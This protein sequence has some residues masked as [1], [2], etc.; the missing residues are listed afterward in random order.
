MLRLLSLAIGCL[1]VGTA[2]C[3]DASEALG[4]RPEYTAQALTQVAN[5][6]AIDKKIWAPGLDEG[7]VPQGI[8]YIDRALYMSAYLSRSKRQSRG[9]CRLYR[10]SPDRGTVTGQLDLPGNCGHAGGL[11]RGP[12][13]TLFV[14]DTR[15]LYLVTLDAQAAG[16]I[17]RVTKTVRLTGDVRGSFAAGRGRFLWLGTYRKDDTGKLYKFDASR[18]G[19]IFDETAALQVVPMPQRSQGAAFD[20]DGRLW[21]S[22]SSGGFGN[23]VRI[24]L[25]SGKAIQSYETAIGVE[26]L[27]FDEAGRLWT[28]SEAGSIRWLSWHQ[29]FPVLYRLDVSK[30]K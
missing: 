24:D 2:H 8:T 18:L 14:A 22:Q 29:F 3:A 15:L 5:S 26:D 20:R 19:E 7:F 11:A 12:Q 10:I 21:V 9:P 1:L 25:A 13:G 23:I 30:L 4:Q 16:R 28:V 6:Q 27:S 17:G